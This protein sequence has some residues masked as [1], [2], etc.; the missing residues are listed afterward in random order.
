MSH[1]VEQRFSYENQISLL[2][3]EVTRYKKLKLRLYEDLNDGIITKDEYLEFKQTYSN[4][5]SEKEQSILRIEKECN[6]AIQTGTTMKN[7]VVIFKEYENFN[8][9]SR[10]VLLA[11]VSKIKVYENHTIE[12]IFKYSDEYNKIVNYI[13]KSKEVI[14]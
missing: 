10:R 2:K 13:L 9:L 3:D 4:I 1:T 12:I 7:W 6:Q 14:K 8:E 11:L 5:E